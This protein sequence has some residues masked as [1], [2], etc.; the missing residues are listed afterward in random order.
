MAILWG[1]RPSACTATTVLSSWESSG[2]P[3]HLPVLPL[4]CLVHGNPL[5]N[6][7]ICLYCHYL[8]QFMETLW[9][10]RPSA[11]TATT[12]LSSWQS[13]GK[14]GHLSVLSL[15]GFKGTPI[16]QKYPDPSVEVLEGGFLVKKFFANL[17]GM[18]LYI[19]SEMWWGGGGG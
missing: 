5:G 11:C 1:T 7:A 19:L 3:G 18:C 13:S 14:P 12:V 4:P 16:R 8:N 6:Q 9:G 10:T 17:D 2:G 15:P